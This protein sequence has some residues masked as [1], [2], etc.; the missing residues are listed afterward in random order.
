MLF[1]KKIRK[2]KINIIKTI[3]NQKIAIFKKEFME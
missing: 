2:N 1:L 3:K